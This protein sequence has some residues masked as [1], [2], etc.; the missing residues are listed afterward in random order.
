MVDV[1][2]ELGGRCRSYSAN[3]EVRP[4]FFVSEKKSKVFFI[5][6]F[7]FGKVLV[8]YTF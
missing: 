1:Y 5:S 3:F 7:F 6:T 8:G 2:K 4:F